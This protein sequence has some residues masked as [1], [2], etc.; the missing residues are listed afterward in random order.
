MSGWIK[1]HRKIFE[2]PFYFS[3]KFTR[4]QAWIDLL[5]LANFKDGFFYKRGIKVEV[6]RGQI[7]YDLDSLANRWTWSR[8][9]VE[10]FI[11]DLE[12]EKQV[13]RQK[14]NITTLITVINYD[15]YQSDDNADS[16]AN[17][18]A[19]G[20]KTVTQ[21]VTQTET[22]K[23]DNKVNKDKE[24]IIEYPENFSEKRKELFKTWFD[25]K[26]EQHKFRYKSDK[27]IKALFAEF[28]LM[29][30]TELEAGIQKSMAAGY[31]GIIKNELNQKKYE[32]KYN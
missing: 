14:T 5:L 2:N 10:R 23:K 25:Y 6:S 28:E 20:N 21:T 30:D 22:N 13:V 1:L 9:K 18:N 3:E 29:T 27:S 32:S 16:N 26:S 31:K 4:C 15:I 24:I 12:N 11:I 17:N 7:G 19:D 8:G